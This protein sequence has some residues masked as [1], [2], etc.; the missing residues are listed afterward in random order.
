MSDVAS[1]EQPQAGASVTSRALAI[2]AAFEN[3]T[4]S[5]SVARIAQKAHLPLSTTYRLVRE[6]EEWGGLR[7]G[8]DG[9]YQIGFRI[10]ELGQLAGRRLRDRA[11]PFLQ[12]LFEL[13]HEN[14]HMAI[15]DGMQTLYVDKVYGSR[16][17]PVVSRI[18]GRLPMHATAVGRV[19][20]SAQPQWFIDA[21][22]Q[23]ELEAPTPKTITD[24]KLLADIITDVQRDGFSV[25]HE[26]MRVGM[27]S[28]AL[29]VH[30]NGQVVASVGL[31]F[32]VIRYREVQR[33][34]PL[35]RGTV[36]RIEASMAGS[37]TRI[38]G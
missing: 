37:P 16:K 9:K 24:P 20:L 1:N 3:S 2:L 14:V 12:D 21:Y 35:L 13:T 25:T 6:L 5:L 32:E 28:M 11:H 34:M 15:R 38:V 23:R 31:V 27:L 18:G 26:Q 36:E 19:L 30:Y 29:P 4:G 33:L 22:L 8:S 10:W 7:K 17:M